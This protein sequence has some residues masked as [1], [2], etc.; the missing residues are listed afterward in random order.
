MSDSLAW[1]KMQ[2]Y[3]CKN[4]HNDDK[5]GQPSFLNENLLHVVDKKIRENR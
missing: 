4:A 2:L 5:I 3:K 1:R